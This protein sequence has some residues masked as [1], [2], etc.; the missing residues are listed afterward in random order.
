MHSSI[1]S[2]LDMLPLRDDPLCQEQNQQTSSTW[3]YIYAC[4]HVTHLTKLPHVTTCTTEHR[5]RLGLALG[6]QKSFCYRFL[7]FFNPNLQMTFFRQKFLF[8]QPKFLMTFFSHFI[9]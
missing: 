1:S 6:D 5:R 2:C 7:K 9:I 4:I 3:P 8:F